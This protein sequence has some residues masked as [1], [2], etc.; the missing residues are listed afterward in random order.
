MLAPSL[1]ADPSLERF[2]RDARRLQRAVRDES[3]ERHAEALTLV[4]LHHPGGAPTD[5]TV[6]ALTAA[7]HV[8]ARNV[9][10]SSWPRL[11]AYLRTA[12]TL[13][14]DP[15]TAVDGDPL[16][17]FLS[18]ACLTYTQDDGPA[19]WSAAAEVLRSHPELPER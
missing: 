5:V 17:Q 10:F 19:R 4:S 9:G 13:R 1:P 2:R 8:V 3:N 15:T 11:Q 6:F 16:A 14:R 7:Q 12:E 18:L